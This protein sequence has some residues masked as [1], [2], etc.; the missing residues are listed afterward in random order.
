MPTPQTTPDTHEAALARVVRFFEQ[1]KPEDLT[2]LAALYC[3]DAH[4]KDPFNEVTG[5]PAIQAIFEHMFETLHAPRFVITQCVQQGAQCCVTWDFSFEFRNFA[6]GTP[7]TIRG[8]SHLVLREEH[9]TWRVGVHRDYWDAAEE[10]YE[11]LP[12][13]GALMRWLKRRAN[14]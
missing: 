9:G 2:Q 4:F 6:R 12:A 14:T 1:L 5:V 13:V 11:K 3:H 8:A 10:L 7:Q